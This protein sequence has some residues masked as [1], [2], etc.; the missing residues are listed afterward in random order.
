MQLLAPDDSSSLAGE[1]ASRIV[2]DLGIPP[3]PALVT[4]LLD[5]AR[6]EDPDFPRIAAIIAHDPAL[7]AAL[8]KTV[9][10]PFYSVVVKA[11]TV[12]QALLFLGLR[13]AVRIVTGLA[14]RHAF[15]AS[16]AA[17]ADPIWT[18]AARLA[19][20]LGHLAQATRRADRDDAYTFGLFRDGGTLLFAAKHGARYAES[21]REQGFPHTLTLLTLEAGL[22]GT[23]HAHAGAALAA[24]WYLPETLCQA[25]R[26]HHDG[27]ALAEGLPLVSREARVLV[28]LGFL[29]DHVLAA[30]P[31]PVAAVVWSRWKPQVLDVLGL[32]EDDLPALAE[33][34]LAAAEDD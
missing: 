32:D 16:L 4:E 26:Y 19:P 23:D 10:S 34:A 17:V 3:C 2:A 28:A 33:E 1:V 5:E 22:A 30:D 18:H 20:V 13:S 29:A 14:M 7:A 27:R 12:Q 6:R 9:N 31:S 15:P 11:K 25:V 8:L 21:L 24:S